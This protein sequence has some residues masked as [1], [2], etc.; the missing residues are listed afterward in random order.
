MLNSFTPLTVARALQGEAPLQGVLVRELM[1]VVSRRVRRT[2]FVRRGT[3]GLQQVDDLVQ[4]VLAALLDRDGRRLRL[5]DPERGASLA[6]F[7]DRVSLHLVCSWLRSPRR[8][9][10]P[11]SAFAPEDLGY[12]EAAEPCPERT[13]GARELMGQVLGGMEAHLDAADRPLF[14]ALVIDEA[15]IDELSG[16]HGISAGALYVRRCRMKKQAREIAVRSCGAELAFA[17]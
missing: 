14:Q 12:V 2:L 7:V 5:W 13:V 1:R 8:S 11:E 9:A 15:D 3:Q 17:A 6:T 16:L 4:D 10:G